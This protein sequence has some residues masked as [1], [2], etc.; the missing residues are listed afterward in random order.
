LGLGRLVEADIEA[1]KDNL[2]N[3]FVDLLG[4]QFLDDEVIFI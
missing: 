2:R 1:G 4:R 3:R